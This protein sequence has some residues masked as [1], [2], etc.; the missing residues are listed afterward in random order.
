MLA[1][2]PHANPEP[3]MPRQPP[4]LTLLV[5]QPDD[6]ERDRLVRLLS[7][8]PVRV[9]A[10]RDGRAGL[11]LA[12]DGGPDILVADLQPGGLDGPALVERVREMRDG[13]KVIVTFGPY[14]PKELVR[15][16][17]VGADAF[18]RLPVDGAKLRETVRRCAREIG[19]AR[20]LAREDYSLRQL[21]DFFPGPALLA[22]G[23]A[24]VCMNRRLSDFLGFDDRRTMAALD[25][26]IED[27]IVRVG[28]EPYGGHPTD[29]MEAV[30]HDPLDRDHILHLRNPR[31]PDSRPSAFAVI[32]NAFPGSDLRLFTFQDVS[33]LEDERARLEDEAATDPLTLALNRRGFRVLL[34]RAAADGAPFSLVMFDIDHFKSVNDTWGHDAGDAVL[35]ETAALVRENIRET[36]TLARWGG[37]EFMVLSRH[38]DPD[39]AL[40]MAER[41]RRAVAGYAFDGVPRTVTASFGVAFAAPGR[42]PEELVRRVDAALYRAKETGRNRVVVDQM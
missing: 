3:I 39:R 36:D 24:V 9:L 28:G 13:V 27:C 30:V 11:D 29:W 33:G 8:D 5:I 20:R 14:S 31:H 35:R 40:G 32:H 6:F 23:Q 7:G 2:K 22:D 41:L 4:Q 42:S 15:A 38:P 26:G 37:E 10:A 1:T 34:D 18:L 25:R 17:E 16:V 19:A 12:L 21:L